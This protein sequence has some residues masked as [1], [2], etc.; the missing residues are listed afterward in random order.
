MIEDLD[1][2]SRGANPFLVGLIG[3]AFFALALWIG[4]KIKDALLSQ[5]HDYRRWKQSD[6]IKR[7]LIYNYYISKDDIQSFSKGYFLLI[8]NGLKYLFALLFFSLAGFSM[9]LVGM[10]NVFIAVYMYF[11]L[12]L[13]Y[14]GISWFVKSKN[15]KSLDQYDKNLVDEMRKELEVVEITRKSPQLEIVKATY[16][17]DLK[18]IDVT[19]DIRKQVINNQLIT[20]AIND[21]LSDPHPGQVKSLVVEY[22]F[23]GIRLSESYTEGDEVLLPK[24]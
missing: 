11:L 17:T 3:S 7:I 15:Q 10:P 4:R 2:W 16:G 8:Y 6:E 12:I 19:Q 9:S 22:I 13:F 1:S 20:R 24:K 21:V 14:D 23:D 5:F 18:K